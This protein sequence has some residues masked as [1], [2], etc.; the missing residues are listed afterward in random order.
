LERTTC[1]YGGTEIIL[2]EKLTLHHEMF[3]AIQMVWYH[4]YYGYLMSTIIIKV[5]HYVPGTKLLPALMLIT[6]LLFLAQAS[7]KV[8]D[9]KCG[10]A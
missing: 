5:I 6:Q 1:G 8:N 10:V 2:Q 7:D 9:S 4:L 3:T